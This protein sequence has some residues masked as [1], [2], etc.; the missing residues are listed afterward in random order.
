VP[1]GRVH[2]AITIAT[3][4]GVLAPYLIVQFGGNPYFYVAGTL[5]GLLVTPDLDID[6]GNISDTMIRKVFPPAQWIWRILWTPYAKL[7]SHRSP[8]SHFPFLGTLFRIGYIFLL[9]NLFNLL[10][11]FFGN[12]FDTVS[13]FIWFWNWSFFFGLC[14][15]DICH[16]VADITIKSKEQFINE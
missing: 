8:I 11:F 14:H 15:V 4:S 13:H 9:L 3:T 7:I 2:S 16:Y 5:M 6:A 1:G 10:F 12:M